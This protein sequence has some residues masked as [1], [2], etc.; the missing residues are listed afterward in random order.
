MIVDL[1]SDT[2]TKPSP[3]MREAIASA[4]VGDDVFGE[5]PTVNLLQ[6]RVASM[7]GKEAALF[8]V[9]GTMGN[10]VAISAHTQPGDEVILETNSH[11]FNYEGGAPALLSGVQ[12]CPLPGEKGVI[13]AE[14]IESAIRSK[15]IHH[16]NTSLICLENTHNMAG[17]TI[18]PLDEIRRIREIAEAHHLKMHLDGAR[19]WNAFVATGISFQEYGRYFDSISVCFSKGLGA[20]VGSMLVGSTEY[21]NSARRY[22]KIYGGGMRQAGILA[23]AALYALDNNLER[24]ADDHKNARKLAEGIN[25]LPDIHIDMDS[26][27]TNIVI[28]EI[29]PKKYTAEQVVNALKEGGVLLLAIDHSHLRAVTHLDVSEE[30]IN[31]AIEAFEEIFA[32]QKQ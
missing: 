17:G 23:A 3:G 12:L 13:T 24:L 5:D 27:Q 4:E 6:D 31:R 15:D 29:N 14:Q 1:R 8:V 19:L 25:S 28:M 2:F 9:S 7:F 20:P 10:E 32:G 30:G 21:I 11:I 16:P 22:R 18:Y 26:V